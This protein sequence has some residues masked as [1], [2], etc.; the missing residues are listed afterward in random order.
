MRLPGDDDTALEPRTAGKWSVLFQEQTVIA[1]S[2]AKI[3]S[4]LTDLS[5]Y[6]EWNPWIPSAEGVLEP[7]GIVWCDVVLG[8]KKQRF[9]HVVL[10]VEPETRLCWRDAGWNSAFVYG[11]RN[12]SLQPQPDGTVLF[13]QEILIDG[14]LSKIAS[15]THGPSLRTGLRLETAALKQRAEARR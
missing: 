7:G 4:V 14:L 8:E 15:L 6:A 2:P 5:T 13:T 3:W 9:K 12:R 11:Q 10:T 1:A